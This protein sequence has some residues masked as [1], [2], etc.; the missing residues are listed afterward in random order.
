MLQ[1]RRDRLQSFDNVLQHLQVRRHQS[2]PV[3]RILIGGIENV[4]NRAQRSQRVT[5][6]RRIQQVNL[7]MAHP[8]RRLTT[9]PRNAHHWPTQA[10]QLLNQSAP[11][12]AI[13]ADHQRL[14]HCVHLAT[15]RV[16]DA[17]SV[18]D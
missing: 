2:R 6:R 10:G 3:R 4:T 13:G 9:P 14:S 18:I 15:P 7:Q 17:L 1:R 16:I 11:N 5:R 12:H 8:W